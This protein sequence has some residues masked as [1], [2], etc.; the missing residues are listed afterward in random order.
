MN[1]HL[2]EDRCIEEA[3][4]VGREVLDSQID[5]VSHH[6]GGK[7]EIAVSAPGGSV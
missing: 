6:V 3:V 5:V 1:T 7:V 4:E 2:E